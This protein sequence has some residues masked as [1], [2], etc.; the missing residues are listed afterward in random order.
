MRY[1]LQNQLNNIKVKDSL[2]QDSIFTSNTQ[3][4]TGANQQQ[5]VH[6]SITKS[7]TEHSPSVLNQKSN[8]TKSGRDQYLT[9]NENSLEDGKTSNFNIKSNL[10]T[11]DIIVKN[12]SKNFADKTPDTGRYYQESP[13]TKD[14][15]HITGNF[16]NLDD[17]SGEKVVRNILNYQTSGAKRLVQN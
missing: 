9:T 6:E 5:S 17:E 10:D 7:A 4:Q 16:N 11:V 8:Y 3:L 12:Q 14:S 13:D 1:H 2:D 15:K